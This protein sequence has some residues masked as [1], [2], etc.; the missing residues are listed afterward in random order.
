MTLAAFA[1][2]SGLPLPA[3]SCTS[4]VAPRSAAADFD[5]LRTDLV[6]VGIGVDPNMPNVDA[7]LGGDGLN[8]F[9]SASDFLPSV[10]EVTA[11]LRTRRAAAG[12]VAL[13]V[14]DLSSLSFSFSFSLD[15]DLDFV[16][17]GVGKKPPQPVAPG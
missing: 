3:S 4:P 16:G 2:I 1:A 14:D 13:A 8:D 9:F 17:R 10:S 11:G 5:D 15:L 7:R 6:R 12:D